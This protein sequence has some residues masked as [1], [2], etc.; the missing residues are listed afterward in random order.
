MTFE[1]IHEWSKGTSHVDVCWKLYWVL[2]QLLQR[3][4]GKN[5]LD[6]FLKGS[7]GGMKCLREKVGQGSSQVK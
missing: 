7:V 2:E 3:A 4:W 5:G 1:Q 6:V